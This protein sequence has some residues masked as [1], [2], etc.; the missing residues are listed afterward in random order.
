MLINE[1]DVVL[2]KAEM[3]QV[4]NLTSITEEEVKDVEEILDQKLLR[5]NL[6]KKMLKNKLEKHLRNYKV[7]LIKVKAQNTEEIKEINIENKLKLI[8]KLQQ[9]KAKY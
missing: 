7:N 5:K 6:V 3:H 4:V 1:K 2:V 8:K 9:Q